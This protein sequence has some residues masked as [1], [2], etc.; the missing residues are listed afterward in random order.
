MQILPLDFNRDNGKDSLFLDNCHID[1]FMTVLN[2][3]ASVVNY[4]VKI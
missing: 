1:I 4:I 3:F 2:M